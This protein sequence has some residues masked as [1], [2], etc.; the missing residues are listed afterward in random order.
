MKNIIFIVFL[1]ILC[2]M[3]FPQEI[4]VYDLLEPIIIPVGSGAGEVGYN[5][6]WGEGGG[7]A[8]PTFYAFS[9]NGNFYPT[10][11]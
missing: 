6:Y 3:L 7:Y 4:P 1:F 11:R 8:G 5:K 2:T 9:P 10:F